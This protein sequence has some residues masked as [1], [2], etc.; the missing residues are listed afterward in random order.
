MML[1]TAKQ[2][3]NKK[4]EAAHD[5]PAPNYSIRETPAPPSD[6]TPL[7]YLCFATVSSPSVRLSLRLCPLEAVTSSSTAAVSTLNPKL[8]E[9]W[10]KKCEHT[11]V[12]T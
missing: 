4:V 10:G 5:P 6:S 12:F 7:T 3:C 2:Q 9:K 1:H 8:A 11:V